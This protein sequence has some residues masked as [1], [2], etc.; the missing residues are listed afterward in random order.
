MKKHTKFIILALVTVFVTGCS[1]WPDQKPAPEPE[2]EIVKVP[3]A[4]A[5]TAIEATNA[6]LAAGEAIR[7]VEQR[8]NLWPETSGMLEKANEA[9]NKK[10]YKDARDL[11]NTAREQAETALV[12]S[13]RSDALSIIKTLR[14]DYMDRMSL[15]QQESLSS[16][17]FALNSGKEKDA[18]ETVAGIMND[19]KEQMAAEAAMPKPEP[20]MASYTVNRNDTLWDIAAK[21][22]VYGN[23]DM[24]PLLWK[25]N[26]ETIKRPDDIAVGMTLAIDR[27][28][29]KEAVDA[30]IVFSKL[31]GAESL[32]PVDTFDQQYLGK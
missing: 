27:A 12:E 1:A 25:A 21:P 6:I 14:A 31:R 23:V 19:L 7:N 22:E 26:K 16:A 13:Y 32:G 11:A 9:M 20:E 15:E 3:E 18:Y 5:V 10:E 29:T 4:P 28:A 30:A 17:D 24:W 8:G 2:P